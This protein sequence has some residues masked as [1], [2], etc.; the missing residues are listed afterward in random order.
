[1]IKFFLSI[2]FILI[3]TLN[4]ISSCLE[5]DPINTPFEN[6]NPLFS[7]GVSLFKQQ[8]D[9]EQ[10]FY[11]FYQIH[12][13]KGI[14]NRDSRKKNKYL[15]QDVASARGYI[16]WMYLNGICVTKDFQQ[17][18]IWFEKAINSDA[19]I[20]D[21]TL[22]IYST[23]AELYLD[24]KFKLS[25]PNL[26]LKYLSTAIRNKDFTK[27]SYEVDLLQSSI[28]SIY[29]LHSKNID[30]FLVFS[31]ALMKYFDFDLPEMEKIR[32]NSSFDKLLDKNGIKNKF[33]KIKFYL[34][35]ELIEG[36]NIAKDLDVG[37]R[38]IISAGRKGSITEAGIYAS[39]INEK[40]LGKYKK[41]KKYAIDWIDWSI[42]RTS[43][44][45]YLKVLE[46]RKKYIISNL[47]NPEIND[48][49]GY[50]D[51]KTWNFGQKHGLSQSF[52]LEIKKLGVYDS[53][54]L[55]SAIDR[56]LDEEYLDK[57]FKTKNELNE[58]DQA[59]FYQ[60]LVDE[61]KASEKLFT[62]AL[63]I[64][65]K[66]EKELA[67]KNEEDK[68]IRAKERI[69]EISDK[70]YKIIISCEHFDSHTN[71]NACLLGDIKS[72]IK[73]TIK[74]NT[75]VYQPW[76]LQ[77][78]GNETYEGLVFNISGDS[79]I[80]VSNVSDYLILKIK[81]FDRVT[82]KLIRTISAGYLDYAYAKLN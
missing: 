28:E 74:S 46:E 37:S 7:K 72:N 30:Q 15:N 60:F 65:R 77:K 34:G 36:N 66:R 55:I 33:Y 17:A 69:K 11:T 59:I 29:E 20:T 14:Y 80:G 52:I 27:E 73:V 58:K 31:L 6:K 61:K 12:L 4:S 18:S 48:I 22:W 53:E 50:S 76:D 24:Q 81:V 57:S 44:S 8:K 35:K 1:M 40:G 21:N 13:G 10:A 67:K 51:R 26:G 5:K 68:K 42:K 9:F 71:I 62:S 78:L 41:N 43:D 82:N 54:S 32:K 38:L 75:F 3:I 47:T 70:P 56:G 49:Y 23:T 63:D 2:F 45:S 64:K 16:A 79:T 19:K 39:E 25:K